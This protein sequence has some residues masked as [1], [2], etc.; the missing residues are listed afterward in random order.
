MSSYTYKDMNKCING[1]EG[2]AHLYSTMPT[3]K[4]KGNDENR[5]S[6]L[7]NHQGQPGGTVV[8]SAHSASAAQGSPVWMLGADM[9]PLGKLCCGRHPTYKVEEDGHGC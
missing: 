3:S 9:A 1:G 6:T 7:K 2:K 5:K 8:K 4:C